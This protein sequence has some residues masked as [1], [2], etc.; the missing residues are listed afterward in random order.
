SE[1][2]SLLARTLGETIDIEHRAGPGLW[3]ALADSGQLQNALLNLTLN[4][5]DAMP[6]GGVLT[7]ECSNVQ[8]DE[9]FAAAHPDLS[10][11]DYVVMAVSDTGEGMTT[12]VQTRAFEP[13]FSTKGVGEGSG[14]GLSMVYGFTKQSGGTVT[15]SSE[16]GR[17]TTVKLYLPR[18]GFRE[19]PIIEEAQPRREERGKGESVLLIEDD[20]DVRSLTLEMLKHL[21]YQVTD[22]P[23]AATARQALARE[24]RFDLVL[25]DVVLPGG[26]SGPE[27]AE[28]AIRKHPNLKVLFMSGHSAQTAMGKGSLGEKWI[29]LDK[30]FRMERL[31]KALRESL[32]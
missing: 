5:R 29:L 17:G 24:P 6:S 11:G 31:A 19:A 9:A 4:A 22:V 25:S 16:Q 7:I 28:E 21:G 3:H 10:P 14:L 26:T 13:F 23:D 1:M 15:I 2:S 12:E 18:A 20:S 27:F 30:P 32:D 8:L